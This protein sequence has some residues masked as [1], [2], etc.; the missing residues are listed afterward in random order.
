MYNLKP[1]S[2]I[3]LWLQ[4]ISKLYEVIQKDQASLY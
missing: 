2:M 1:D 4:K 3:F